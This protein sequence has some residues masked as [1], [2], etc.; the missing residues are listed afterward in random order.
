[1]F[2]EILW[3]YITIKGLQGLIISSIDVVE[4]TGVLSHVLSGRILHLS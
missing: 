1:M 3:R 4:L 2:P